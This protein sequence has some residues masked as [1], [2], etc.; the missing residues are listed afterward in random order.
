MK[1]KPN[2]SIG[3]P[4][5]IRLNARDVALTS[6]FAALYVALGYIPLFYI[7]GSYGQYMTAALIFAPITGIVLGPVGGGLATAIG[8]I[9]GMMLTGNMPMGIFSFLPGTFGALCV[10]LTYRGR[11][12]ASAV[13]FA[14]FIVAFAA[15]PSIGAA[16]YYV[17]L[18]AFALLLLVSP[19]STLAVEYTKSLDPQKLVFGV[20]I[21]AFIGVL[22]DHIVGSFLYQ[23]LYPLPESVWATFAFVYPLER[24]LV[25]IVAAII[26]VGII[27]GVKASGLTI[28]EII[29]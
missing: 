5:L 21:L 1:E 8:G 29:A 15:L 11:W 24:L 23:L 17:W 4:Y 25:T 19:A 26:G 3:K 22:V 20:S 18:H 10:G 12:Y 13:I 6:I 16:K 2:A 14:F 7:F 27:K 9:I 28:G